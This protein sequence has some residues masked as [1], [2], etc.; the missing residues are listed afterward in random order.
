MS[1]VPAAVA[2]HPVSVSS[3]ELLQQL[4]GLS[5][6][7]SDQL[8]LPEAQARLAE[9]RRSA[10]MSIA[11]QCNA[12]AREAILADVR[13]MLCELRR[14]NADD[15]SVPPDH[16]VLANEC[17]DAGWD[18]VVAAMLAAPAWQ[19]QT[20]PRLRDMPVWLI[21]AGAE[22]LF[23]LP[24]LLTASGQAQ[25]AAD[26]FLR[27]ASDLAGFV[28]SN[29]G[30]LAVR[31]AID[32]FRSAEGL[33]CL[34]LPGPS[35]RAIR[36]ARARVVAA[37]NRDVRA[38]SA[39]ALPRDGRPLRV[40]IVARSLEPGAAVRSLLPLVER[41]AHSRFE[42]FV[43]T[44]DSAEA[45]HHLSARGAVCIPL[46]VGFDEQLQTLRDAAL[47]VA[48]YV[49]EGSWTANGL[50]ATCK[51]RVAPL[52]IVHDGTGLPASM[53]GADLF[54]TT[55]A[56]AQPKPLADRAA[57]VPGPALLAS[58]ELMPAV[59]PDSWTREAMG[60]ESDAIVLTA[61]GSVEQFSREAVDEWAGI[62]AQ[63]PQARLVICVPEPQ[64]S[65]TDRFC[66]WL[67]QLLRNSGVDESRVSVF[68]DA[69][70]G[71]DVER[72]ACLAGTDVLIDVEGTGV[73][74]AISA[75]R[76]GIPVVTVNKSQSSTGAVLIAAGA[77]ELVVERASFA[78]TVATIVGAPDRRT[79]LAE[80]LRTGGALL[81]VKHDSFVRSEQFARLIENAF[82]SV[83][84]GQTPS[85][86][87]RKALRLVL[88]DAPAA[89][90]EEFKMFMELGSATDAEMRARTLL[91][92]APSESAPRAALAQAL[93]RQDRHADAAAL[94][95]S[96]VEL[97]PED[98]AAWH[99]LAVSSRD[100]GRNA[101]AVQALQTALRL[102]PK[103]IESWLL[104]SAIAGQAG[105]EEMRRDV[106]T[107]LKELAPD[108]PQV[109]EL[110][111]QTAA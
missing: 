14:V 105:D 5:A 23:S 29:R 41:L 36:A 109:A 31:A 22:Y 100:A 42:L 64:R 91:L 12:T 58:D 88:D 82:D 65:V 50:L 46:P 111:A 78:T 51:G 70:L 8:F 48:V 18:G 28:E 59:A 110:V 104:L 60:L 79:R 27:A 71:T 80:T 43:F 97:T 83:V 85:K 103:R 49:V 37:L 77:P 92:L 90:A 102:N 32:A 9:W 87:S 63:L 10:V 20:A 99:D 26:Q 54:F 93:V 101:D 39:F 74:V 89:V 94:W 95:L 98:A 40:G 45:E 69:K 56:E 86:S 25:A 75:I 44:S 30:S 38:S 3:G 76:L 53:P 108:D 1:T 21:P 107:V 2:P 16:L 34:A 72:Q 57:I 52:Q 35:A 11:T 7:I 68:S 47:D 66:G 15:F 61:V 96:V 6:E 84:A 62:L 81:A 67:A 17:A 55:N 24:T 4:V 106:A 13:A 33:P 73:D 19:W